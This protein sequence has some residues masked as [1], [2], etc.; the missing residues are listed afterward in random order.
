MTTTMQRDTSSMPETSTAYV[1]ANPSPCD[2]PSRQRRA[3]PRRAAG[4]V[5]HVAAFFVAIR[6][7]MKGDGWEYSLLQYTRESLGGDEVLANLICR[8]CREDIH[9]KGELCSKQREALCSDCGQFVPLDYYG[10]CM[11]AGERAQYHKI[12]HSTIRPHFWIQHAAPTQPP[13]GDMVMSG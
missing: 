5:A 3:I 7:F 4:L 8:V 12:I 9:D 1:H 2:S 10:Q 11:N 13:S 6:E